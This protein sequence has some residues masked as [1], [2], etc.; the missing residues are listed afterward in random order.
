MTTTNN[1]PATRKFNL[2]S[3]MHK[4]WMLV[5]TYGLNL[6]DAL[7]KSWLIA[8]T[9]KAMKAGVAHFRFTKADGSIRDAFGRLTDVPA[10][11][12]KRETPAH[13]VTYWDCERDAW[14]CFKAI[15][16]IELVA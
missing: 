1:T 9:I 14:R 7:R 16:F 11:A 13:L 2:K 15:N 12:G 8:K 3:I 6:A 10:T 5:R 4:A